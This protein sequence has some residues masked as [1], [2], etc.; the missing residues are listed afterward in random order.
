MFDRVRN[1]A[2][3]VATGMS[4]RGFITCLGRGAAALVAL[5][6]SVALA[7]GPSTCIPNGGCCGTTTPY[8]DSVKQQCSGSPTCAPGHGFFCS[9]STCCNGGG[10]CK[11]GTQC[12]AG[13]GCAN[14]C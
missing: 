12:M 2:E 14:P 7:A 8:Y 3:R 11:Q 6:G 1:T 4:R 10:H 13:P 9:N 5:G